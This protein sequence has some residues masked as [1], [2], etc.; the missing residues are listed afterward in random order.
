MTETPPKPLN[1]LAELSKRTGVDIRPTLLRVITDLYVQKATHSEKE[2]AEYTRM[3]LRLLDHVDA[4]TRTMI[5]G[6]IAGYPNAPAAVRQR[7]L[8]DH[9]V[10]EAPEEPAK[11]TARI[12]PPKNELAKREP[13][14]REP[15][16]HE[17]AKHK[18]AKPAP[19]PKS[20]PKSEPKRKAEALELNELFF[21]CNAEERRLILLNLSYAPIAPAGPIDPAAA[22]SAIQHLEASALAHLTE[23]FARDLG[24][25]L[26]ISQTQALRLTNDPGGEPI[27]VAAAALQMPAAV[28][29]R[30][31]LCLN[32]VISRSVQRVYDL[33]QL[34]EELK[35]EAALRLVAL[36]QA[37]D[38]AAERPPAS[39]P[40]A[41]PPAPPRSVEERIRPAA[42]PLARPKIL[43]EQHAQTRRA[44]SA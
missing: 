2:E 44:D 20:E 7:L 31:L 4:K 36:W 27:V 8:K 29:A 19:D 15:A 32:P 3:A 38:R 35:A 10:C 41:V 24:R 1:G 11:E 42:A 9:I 21:A 43:W 34:H 33:T 12:E 26:S 28:L 14:K 22:Q 25:V 6:K 18:P 37:A 16:K 39:A 13:A 30:I 23:R 17:P 40:V 5:A